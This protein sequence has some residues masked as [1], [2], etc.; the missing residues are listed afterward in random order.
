MQARQRPGG[1]GIRRTQAATSPAD[2]HDGYL[3]PSTSKR[4]CIAECRQP[5]GATEKHKASWT[6]EAEGNNKIIMDFG[7][8]YSESGGAHASRSN[9]LTSFSLEG[10]LEQEAN[11][12][13]RS[14]NDIETM[15]KKQGK[16]R[17]TGDTG[18]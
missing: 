14:V 5:N 6:G 12:A 11:P 17:G 18:A 10:R 1:K 2:Q 15:R 7:A 8:R 9:I 13:G 4:L 3:V 16:R